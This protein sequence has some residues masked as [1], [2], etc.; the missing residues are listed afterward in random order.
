MGERAATRVVRVAGGALLGAFAVQYVPATVTLGQ[1]GDLRA[2]PGR[3]CRWQ[4]PAGRREVALTFDDGPHPEATPA[5]L[6]RLADLGLRATFFVLA[7]EARRHPE[8]VEEIARRGHAIGTHGGRHEHHLARTPGWVH[9]DLAEADRVMVQLGHPCR[10]YRPTFGQVTGSTL[11]LAR[12]RGWEP[13][14][15]S[16]WGREWTTQDP[17]AVAGRIRRRLQPGAI[18]L[19]HD[20]DRFGPPGMWRVGLDALE[21]VAADLDELQLQAVTLDELC[22]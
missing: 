10:W 12:R 3:L 14:L 1:W 4:G 9:R 16:A 6:D 5:V 11:L 22:R 7:S 8:L 13:V 17:Y 15:W 20:S 21:S 19:L 2:L 18:V